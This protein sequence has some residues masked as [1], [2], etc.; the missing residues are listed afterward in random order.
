MMNTKQHEQYTQ[1][2]QSCAKKFPGASVQFQGI[3]SISR[4]YRHPEGPLALITCQV[5]EC[6]SQDSSSTESIQ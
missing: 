3:C 2:N 6:Y 4:S 1:R 5:L